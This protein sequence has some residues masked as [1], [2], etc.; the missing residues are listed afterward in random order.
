MKLH[1]HNHSEYYTAR[2]LITL[3]LF[4][5][6]GHLLRLGIQKFKGISKNIDEGEYKMHQNISEHI[7]RNSEYNEYNIT[8]NTL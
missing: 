6:L 8:Y 3:H 7:E 1:A 2:K 5:P 4:T